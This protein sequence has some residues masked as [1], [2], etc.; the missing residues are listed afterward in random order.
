MGNAL[1]AYV[2]VLAGLVLLLLG[3][4]FLVRSAVALADRLGMSPLFIGLT[5]VAFGTSAPEMVVSL[6]AVLEGAPAI[7]V[8]NVVGSNIAN[9][10]L[11][12]GTAALIYPVACHL[13]VIRRDGAAVLAAT[14]LFAVLSL[15]G[16]LTVVQGSIML[17]CLV[18]YLAYSYWRDRGDQK[19]VAEMA[20]EVEE[21]SG[22]GT[23]PTWLVLVKLAGGIAGVVFGSNVLVHGGVAIAHQF[24]ISEAVIGLTIF[25]IGTSLPELATTA[26]AAWHKHSDLA[27]GNVIGSNIFNL[28]AVMGMV[29][30]VAP[31]PMPEQI[32]RFDLWV[33]LGVT[34]AFGVV[35]I[36]LRRISRPMGAT[37]LVLYAAYVVMLFAGVSGAHVAQAG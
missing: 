10:L 23:Q 14:I 2:Q 25:A 29:S 27:L 15:T 12:L 13:H 6:I 21:M 28:L 17:V 16:T 33:M 19:A 37:F 9:I 11:I 22:A 26:V 35:A 18:G 8:G 20:Q 1:I 36:I 4:E 5:I 30:L 24:G 34:L 7:A 31:V 3:G 32:A